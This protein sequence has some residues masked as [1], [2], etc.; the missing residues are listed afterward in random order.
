MKVGAESTA[1][2]DNDT[3]CDS[4][5][6]TVLYNYGYDTVS[7]VVEPGWQKLHG[8]KGGTR[9]KVWTCTKILSPN[10]RSFV[11]N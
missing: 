11:A 7:D 1:G 6:C 4:Q 9:G 5:K 3:T 2:I 10:I 8:S